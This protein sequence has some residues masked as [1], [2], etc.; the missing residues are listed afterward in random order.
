MI[1]HCIGLSVKYLNRNIYYLTLTLCPDYTRA[2]LA[3]FLFFFLFFFLLHRVPAH[4]AGSFNVL[5]PAVFRP[6]CSPASARSSYSSCALRWRPLHI[7]VLP[8]STPCYPC[9]LRVC[10]GQR[11]FGS[12]PACMFI[13]STLVDARVY[14][15]SCYFNCFL[16]LIRSLREGCEVQSSSSKIVEGYLE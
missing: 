15:P 5:P 11:P 2:L 16:V 9:P 8:L 7:S 1:V 12:S 13:L 14:T 6:A 10:C 3:F 4:N